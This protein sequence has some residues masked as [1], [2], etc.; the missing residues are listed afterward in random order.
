[1]LP[2]PDLADAALVWAIFLLAGVVKG[3]TGFGLPTITL[4]L[5]ALT[6][7]LP[8]AMALT[9]APA[10]ATN[11]WQALAGGAFRPTLRRLWSF[12]LAGAAG[13]WL[14]A[15]VLLA[16]TDAAQLSALL[17]VLLVAS[18]A[19][20]L[21]GPPWPPPRPGRERWL[22]PLMGGA[23]GLLAGLTGSFLVPAAPW[24]AALRLPPA[25]FVQ[26]FALAV[27]AV[28]LPLGAGLARNGLLALESGLTALAGLVPAFLGMAA[29][30]RLRAR[31]PEA[32]FRRAVQAALLVL[33]LYLALRGALAA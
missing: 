19:L 30:Q 31:L 22:Q 13:A 20:A 6:R 18:S 15:G 24:L 21:L 1:M 23:S 17:G 11:V 8:E 9:L 33:G 29:G 32:L 14:G 25:Q 12:A 28:M 10:F 27:L 3:V 2:I 4:G 7:S 16:R 5:L 26:G